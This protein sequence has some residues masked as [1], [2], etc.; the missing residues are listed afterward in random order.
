MASKA[1]SQDAFLNPEVEQNSIEEDKVTK[2]KK[3][4]VY[5]AVAGNT[6][7]NMHAWAEI[8]NIIH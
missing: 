7:H 1:F 8:K 4:S 6:S 5:D 3:V 2:T